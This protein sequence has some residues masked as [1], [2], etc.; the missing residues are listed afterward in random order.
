MSGP[1]FELAAIL[2]AWEEKSKFKLLLV[3]F[4]LLF[5]VFLYRSMICRFLYNIIMDNKIDFV[6]W[7]GT[8]F[9]YF[10]LPSLGPLSFPALLPPQGHLCLCGPSSSLSVVPLNLFLLICPPF[11]FKGEFVCLLYVYMYIST[12]EHAVPVELRRHWIPWA[13]W[14]YRITAL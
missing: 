13:G 14:S 8:I 3:H 10:L 2:I 9:S 12:C 4:N 1:C 11:S 6:S 7:G 5:A